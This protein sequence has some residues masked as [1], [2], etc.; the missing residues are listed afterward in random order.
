MTG[1]VVVSHSH[2]LAT[3]AV[4]LAREMVRDHAPRIEIAAGLSET[5][6]GTDA[7]AIQEAIEQAMDDQGVVVLMDLGSA[8]MSTEMAIEMLDPDLAE[9]VHPTWA[10][11][12]EGL[13][14][15]VVLAS[16]GADPAAVIAEAETGVDAKRTHLATVRG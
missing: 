16:T 3:A 12:V 1:I 13:V 8:I 5:T 15:A 9:R 6:L 4:D 7:T 2:A 10:P 11:L 14:G